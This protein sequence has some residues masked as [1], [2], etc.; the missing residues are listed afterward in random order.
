MNVRTIYGPAD[1]SAKAGGRARDP[2]KSANATPGERVRGAGFKST[3]ATTEQQR[4][5]SAAGSGGDSALRMAKERA[6][7]AEKRAKMAQARAADLERAVKDKAAHVQMLQEELEHYTKLSTSRRPTS[8]EEGFAGSTAS[9][10]SAAEAVAADRDSAVKRLAERLRRAETQAEKR[11]A[12]LEERL[13]AQTDRATRAEARAAT[14]E[15]SAAAAAKSAKSAPGGVGSSAADAAKLAAAVAKLAEADARAANLRRDLDALVD[16]V[17]RKHSVCH[18][19]VD[20]GDDRYEGF[21]RAEAPELFGACTYGCGDR[22]VGEWENG[23]PHG[24]GTC[25]FKKGNSYAGGWREGGYHGEGTYTYA[26]GDVFEGTWV[27]D[28]RHGEGI[29]RDAEGCEHVEVYDMGELKSR[30]AKSGGGGES[31]TS[32]GGAPDIGAAEMR[33]IREE[34]RRR[35]DARWKAFDARPTGKMIDW[36]D[37]P[38]P[39]AGMPLLVENSAATERK[40]R[41][42]EELMRWHPDKW[43]GR[44]LAPHNRDRIMADV[45]NVFRRVDAE[46]QKA[47]L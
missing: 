24:R 29:F 27:D 11:C 44:S 25:R 36:G 5:S 8:R 32:R 31:S 41:C 4:T 21:L 34:L 43:Q 45:T 33:R 14:A 39:P 10:D 47:G 2:F 13:R 28:K 20:D 46:K 3:A 9:R 6:V 18:G 19:A 7:L 1:A 17:S 37:I 12:A 23:Q 35:Y 38:W 26:N 22:Y 30:R 15:A 42:K 16:F 40:R